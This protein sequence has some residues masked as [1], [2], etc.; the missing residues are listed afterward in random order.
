MGERAFWFGEVAALRDPFKDISYLV[1]PLA[2]AGYHLIRSEART[3]T[4][5]GA[6]GGIVESGVVGGRSTSG[7]VKAGQSFEWSISETSRLTQK[8]S[9]IWKV[10]DPE[11]ALYH[12]DAGLV[13]AIADRLELKLSWL[14]DYKNRPPSEEFEKGDSALFA[15]VL[16]KF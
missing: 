4:V 12:F 2:G 9:G 16:V 5:D 6:V 14:Y 13:T 3:L 8:L 11:D 15:A 7:A 1:A 10:D